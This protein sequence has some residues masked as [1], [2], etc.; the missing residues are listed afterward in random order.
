[1]QRFHFPLAQV[2]EFRRRKLELEEAKLETLHA[3]RR[4]LEAESARIETEASETRR[5]LMV[6]GSAESQDLVA[7][8]LYLRHLASA[9]K[10]HATR[11]AEWQARASRQQQLIV[12]ARRHVRLLEKLEERRLAEWKAD[13]DREQENLSSELYLAR[14]KR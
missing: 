12:E 6:T 3:E 11:L 5:S 8:D 7:S 14:W 13:V 10:R 9:K 2:L 4:T 1:V